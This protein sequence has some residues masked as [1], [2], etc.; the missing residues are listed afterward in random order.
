MKL[1]LIRTILSLLFLA[2]L[3]SGVSAQKMYTCKQADGRTS[4]QQ[5]PCD[6]PPEAPADLPAPGAP[7]A[8]SEGPAKPPAPGSPQLLTRGKRE[9]LQLTTMLERCRADQPGFAERSSAVYVAWRQRHAATLAEYDR[10]LAAKVREARR[11]VAPIPLEMC[12][13]DL[14]RRMEPLA[15]PPDA[16][17]DT[18]EKTWNLF[19][20]SLRAGNRDLA[21]RCLTGKA[22]VRWKEKSERA[23][24]A[25]LRRMADAIRAFKVQWGDDYQK[26]ALASRADNKVSGIIFVKFN[27][28]WLISEM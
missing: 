1:P 27:D 8:A 28:E 2:A 3:A 6:P 23:S 12:S 14:L 25:D 9:V 16:R 26:E 17:L 13:D 21:A 4:F 22:E 19:V 15:R 11:G 10:L 7:V 24:D 5:L 18:A 20:T